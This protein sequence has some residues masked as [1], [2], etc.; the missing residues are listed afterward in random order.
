MSNS[1]Q[2]SVLSSSI[3]FLIKKALFQSQLNAFN[4]KH[5]HWIV[6]S[7]ITPLQ[8]SQPFTRNPRADIP[9][10]T[11]CLGQRIWEQQ[12]RHLFQ[13]S[14]LTMTI[15]C[16]C[17]LMLIPSAPPPPACPPNLPSAA[18][19]NSSPPS[20]CCSNIWSLT[21][22]A[23]ADPSSLEYP[24][25]CWWFL[26]SGSIV[27]FAFIFQVWYKTLCR[28]RVWFFFAWLKIPRVKLIYS[29]I[30]PVSPR[31]HQVSSKSL[32]FSTSL[33]STNPSPMYLQS[34]ASLLDGFYLATYRKKAITT[35]WVW[36]IQP[37]PLL[38]W[39]WIQNWKCNWELDLHGHI[40]VLE[41]QKSTLLRR[42][43]A[44]CRC[45]PMW[46][47]ALSS[48]WISPPSFNPQIPIPL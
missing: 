20:I 30:H 13:K 38:L 18:R 15:I 36:W 39:F 19:E 40:A 41:M 25:Y 45:V 27:N 42:F 23:M 46:G 26:S 32:P 12:I 4:R 21:I 37:C 29:C 11:R 10:H 16:Q 2:S 31:Y 14:S 8:C 5:Q 1:T 6:K 28:G 44:H 9:N 7:P 22:V 48:R 34:P 24:L 3:K 43:Y 17:R 33:T 35:S 47:L